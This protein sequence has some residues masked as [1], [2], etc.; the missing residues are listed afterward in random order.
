[1][2]VLQI[3]AIHQVQ[4]VQVKLHNLQQPHSLMIHQMGSFLQTREDQPMFA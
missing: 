4:F 2:F 3:L 1:M